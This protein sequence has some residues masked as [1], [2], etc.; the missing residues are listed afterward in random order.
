MDIPSIQPPVGGFM[1]GGLN[2]TNALTKASLDNRKQQLANQYY[3]PKTNAEIA[4]AISPMSMYGHDAGTLAYLNATNNGANPQNAIPNV[5]GGN[6][7]QRSQNGNIFDRLKSLLGGQQNANSL[8]QTASSNSNSGLSN[9][10]NN[11]P[12]SPQYNEN[13]GGPGS[14]ATSGQQLPVTA[15]E[16]GQPVNSASQRVQQ[17]TNP[18][19]YAASVAA[20]TAAAT[21]ETTNLNHQQ[22][23]FMGLARQAPIIE[24]NLD[25]LVN[26]YKNIKYA[27]GPLGSHLPQF[28]NTGDRDTA[29]NA[30]AQLAS[31][32]APTL[33]NG[34]L[35]V[36]NFDIANTLKPNT[37]LTQEGLEEIKEYGKGAVQRQKEMLPFYNSLKSSGLN[38]AQIEYA[39]SQ[40]NEHSPYY[41]VEGHKAANKNAYKDYTTPEAIA[42]FKNGQEYN[43]N[44]DKQAGSSANMQPVDEVGTGYDSTTG[45]GG[46]PMK[47]N[48]SHVTEENILETM[49]Q[50]KL[51]RNEVMRRLKLKG[52][53]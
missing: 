25:R 13:A 12:P 46:A 26:A 5:F 1:V 48:K 34:H 19:D 24:T 8:N 51:S 44:A 11:P 31:A 50:T 38:S 37:A 21:N 32:V 14:Q 49:K 22:T 40:M 29:L 33:N 45:A 20:K 15:P 47:L 18:A 10:L 43:P 36:R 16:P 41:D 39:I 9:S 35:A 27:K 6:Q 7:Q 28:A 3:G 4:H 42:A 53:V 2:I 23:E 17:I 30:Q 52:L